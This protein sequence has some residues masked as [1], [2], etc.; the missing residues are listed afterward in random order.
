MRKEEDSKKKTK[1]YDLNVC[2]YVSLNF[3]SPSRLEIFVYFHGQ[4]SHWPCVMSRPVFSCQK[5]G[6]CFQ[7]AKEGRDCKADRHRWQRPWESTPVPVSCR[8]PTQPHTALWA[9]VSPFV[10]W[11]WNRCLWILLGQNSYIHVTWLQKKTHGW[12][13][14]QP[15]SKLDKWV[16]EMSVVYLTVVVLEKLRHHEVVS[17]VYGHLWIAKES[18]IKVATS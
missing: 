12:P 1:L 15:S 17:T 9:Q 18:R 6:P 13:F 4:T 5:N 14:F 2:F 10:K 8:E 16:C 3:K 11:C 7:Q